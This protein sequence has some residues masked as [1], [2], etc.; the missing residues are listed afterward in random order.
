MVEWGRPRM[1]IWL[2]RI[3]CWIR[4]ATNTH[5]SCVIFIAFPLPQWLYERASVLRYTHIYASLVKSWHQEISLYKKVK[6]TLCTI[7]FMKMHH[8]W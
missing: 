4:M 7:F 6:K 1:T 8:P 2:M 5:S 3:A